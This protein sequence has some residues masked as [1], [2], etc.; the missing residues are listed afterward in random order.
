[1]CSGSGGNQSCIAC[2][3]RL[4]KEAVVQYD[5]RP[6]FSWNPDGRANLYCTPSLLCT[7]PCYTYSPLVPLFLAN[8]GA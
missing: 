1:M 3:V 7:L 2:V 4:P 8:D 5:E 6:C